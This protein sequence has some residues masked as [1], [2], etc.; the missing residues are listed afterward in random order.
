MANGNQFRKRDLI[1]PVYL[2][3]LLFMMAEGAL[4][5][6]IPA[7]AESFGVGL[8]TAGAV[9]GALMLGALL[10]EIPSALINGILGERRA[11]MLAGVF[12]AIGALLAFI[13]QN[14][15]FLALG[16]AMVGAGH[17]L[18]GLARHA[19]LAEKVPSF[20]R[21]RAMSILGGMFRGGLALGP[22]IGAGFVASLGVNSVYFFAAGVML[23]VSLIVFS[24]DAESM[25][26]PPSENRGRSWMIAKREKSKLR[27]LG[28][29]SAV[30]AGI[31]N[32]RMIALPLFAIS[33]G[34]DPATASLVIG[35]TGIIDFAL[36]YLSGIVMDKYGRFWTSVPT[37]LAFGV[38][39]VLFFTMNDLTTFVIFAALTALVNALSSGINMVLGA[40][41]A[42][43]DAR[44]EFLAGFRLITT[45]GNAFS[46]YV[47][48]GVTLLFGL[49]P[50]MVVM[51]GI[52]FYGAFMFWKFLPKYGEPSQD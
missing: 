29:A 32:I 28:V 7:T 13:G 25:V 5:P 31:R 15:L 39:Y 2:P 4:L 51:G 50:A 23:L 9:A 24:V 48:S 12:G 38:L 21:A 33:L 52:S 18:F 10:A 20:T 30:I 44:S 11:M 43:R 6:I 27:T 22:V 19:F 17:S 3:S 41:L 47:L 36:F 14:V 40:D 49:G 16:A 26:C 8:A 35:L 37:L 42:P 46:P 34:I 1:R 45:G